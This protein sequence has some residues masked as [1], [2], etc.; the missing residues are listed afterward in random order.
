MPQPAT[1]MSTGRTDSELATLA[2]D[3][4]DLKLQNADGTTYRQKLRSAYQES[5][6]QL[7]SIEQQR[8]QAQ[9][10]LEQARGNLRNF[11]R[12]LRKFRETDE[13]TRVLRDYPGG[14][15]FEIPPDERDEC[16]CDLHTEVGRVRERIVG[17]DRT[18]MKL[19][20]QRETVEAT[21]RELES[22][23]DGDIT[24]QNGAGGR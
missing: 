19:R 7:H 20:R 23:A 1:S 11:A 4:A 5:R 6:Q 15:S 16:V 3:E 22:R 24:A 13:E 17:A 14:F 2:E 9:Q 18:L 21:L 10:Q 12:T 8:Q